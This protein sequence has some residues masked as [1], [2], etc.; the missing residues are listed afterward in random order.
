[1]T[2]DS[3][4]TEKQRYVRFSIGDYVGLTVNP[5]VAQEM[6]D[7]GEWAEYKREDVYLTEAEFEGM[8]H[9]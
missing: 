3:L 8:E 9:V 6:I 2:N 4:P 7:S 1:M 5:A